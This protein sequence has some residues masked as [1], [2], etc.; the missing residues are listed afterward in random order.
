VCDVFDALTHP[1]PYKP[2]WSVEEA[3]DEIH[4]L[5]GEQFD[6]AVIAAFEKLNHK[7][8]T[9]ERPGRLLEAVA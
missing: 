5:A 9:G 4:R 1:R 3:L 2:A 8:L 6:P 7:S